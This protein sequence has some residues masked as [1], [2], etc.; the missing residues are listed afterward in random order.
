LK[1][2]QDSNSPFA[3]I[4][5]ETKNWL[6]N[7][8]PKL[9]FISKRDYFDYVYLS[10]NLAE[11]PGSAY[12]KIRNRVNKFK[13][14]WYYEIE[15]ISEDNMYEIK[16]FLKRWCLWKDCES[17]S[18]LLN[19]KK[20]ILYSMSNYFDLG[21]SGISLR[22]EDKIEAIAVYEEMNKDTAV[23]N[24]EKGS[25][26]FEGIYKVINQET[27]KILQKDFKFINR[28]TDMDIPGLRKAKMSYRPHYMIEIFNVNKKSI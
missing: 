7:H 14:N 27:A 15:K 4:D 1:K 28:E 13:R 12:G 25:P 2:K 9:E 26:V 11:L 24:Y 19:E 16:E 10:S 17:N 23:I 5:I 18:L 6:S 20:A 8:Y 21:L 3:F 22:I